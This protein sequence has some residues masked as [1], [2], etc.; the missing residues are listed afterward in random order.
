ML[1]KL[2]NGQLIYPPDTYIHNDVTISN[3]N[4]LPEKILLSHG[5]KPLVE[6]EIP[7]E[8]EGYSYR[9]IYS[10]DKTAIYIEWEQYELLPT[11]E[12]DVSF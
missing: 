6:T 4:L 11:S 3:Y 8:E 2:N 10:E 7:K 12:I 5:W 9:Q 1:V